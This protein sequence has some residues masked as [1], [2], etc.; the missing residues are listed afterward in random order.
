M[1]RKNDIRQALARADIAQ[2]LQHL[3]AALARV[4]DKEQGL[5]FDNETGA[6]Q[7][8]DTA[9]GTLQRCTVELTEPLTSTRLQLDVCLLLKVDGCLHLWHEI[10]ACA[11]VN[12]NEELAARSY[13]RQV[14]LSRVAHLDKRLTPWQL[15]QLGDEALCGNLFA[16]SLKLFA[17]QAPKANVLLPTLRVLAP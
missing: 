11:P 16:R 5:E 3:A 4:F 9:V 10:W 7:A 6:L 12:P 1:R 2:L 14:R 17:F 13:K 8:T 15:R